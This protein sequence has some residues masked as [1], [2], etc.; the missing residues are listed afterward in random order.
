M[1]DDT[2]GLNMPVTIEEVEKTIEDPFLKN[3]RHGYFSFLTQ[4]ILYWL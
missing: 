3:A 1:T 4:V 2:E